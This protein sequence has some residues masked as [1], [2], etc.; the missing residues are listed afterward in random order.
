MKNPVSLKTRLVFWYSAVTAFSLLAIAL[1]T[2]L[3]A[4]SELYSN[5][6]ASLRKVANSL[7]YIIKEEQYS[8]GTKDTK[9]KHRSIN[10]ETFSLLH[11]RKLNDFYGPM[12]PDRNE[13]QVAEEG[14][15][16]IWATIYEHILLNP[17]NYIIQIVDTSGALIWKSRNMID[18]SLTIPE[19]VILELSNDS[20]PPYEYFQISRI[21]RKQNIFYDKDE[22]TAY[23]DIKIND[24]DSRLLIK[25]TRFAIVYVAYLTE[26]I[27]STLN[28]LVSIFLIGIP[29]LIVISII[30]G[31][32]LAKMS[33]KTV[34]EISREA[35]EIT[36]KNLSRRL[37][38]PN[39]RDEIGH[40]LITLN[41][42]IERLERSFIQ[43]RQFTS[44]ASHELRTPLTILRG[45]LEIALSNP[46]TINEYQIIIASALDEVM[47]LSD[48]V[49]SLLELSR[50]DSGQAKMNMSI[51]NISK[52]IADIS[53]DVEILAESKKIVL[54][55]SIAPNIEIVADSARLHQAILNIAD[56][57]VKYT[58]EG[59][60]INIIVDKEEDYVVI[61]IIDNGIGIPESQ[62]NKIFDRF[63]RVDESRSQ[64]IQ[65]SG[66]GLS[67]V[68]WIIEAHN[69]QIA[70]QS[71]IGAGTSFIVRL[72]LK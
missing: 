70:V 51:T 57:A 56:N 72:P 9:N 69:G 13:K 33:L 61:R 66:L 45:E 30:G 60:R 44:D 59:G 68:K 67:I 4:S 28:G 49:E 25:K 63:F 41:K 34:E 38:V 46:K 53:E 10:Y 48:V 12:R 19:G 42:M 58:P 1:F 7:E 32:L 39:P 21:F 31:A 18:D 62:V 11:N 5:L 2:Y 14:K 26:D 15:D 27:Q 17:K 64:E 50:A 16:K 23:F 6:D 29:I 40:L 55:K 35:N 24:Q 54:E 20:L 65:G 52:L 71:S 36:A 3:V 8:L 22:V 43:I 47:R 37:P